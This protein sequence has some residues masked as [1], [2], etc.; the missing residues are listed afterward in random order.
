MSES[1]SQPFT[2]LTLGKVILL[3]IFLPSSLQNEKKN[4]YYSQWLFS[5]TWLRLTL[6]I[7]E[8][9]YSARISTLLFSTT[10]FFRSPYVFDWRLSL[11]LFWSLFSFFFDLLLILFSCYFWPLFYN[12]L[13]LLLYFIKFTCTFNCFCCLVFLC[14]INFQFSGFVFRIIRLEI[15]KI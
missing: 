5:P 3:F 9:G 12:A 1:S 7:F 8:S 13:C 6:S 11:L 15:M 10:M 2:G 4:L 14:F